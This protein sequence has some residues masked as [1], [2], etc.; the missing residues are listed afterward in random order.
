MAW[1]VCGRAGFELRSVP[2]KRVSDDSEGPWVARSIAN[3]SGELLFILLTHP[4]ESLGGRPASGPRGV[5]AG[6]GEGSRDE[7]APITFS[8]VCLRLPARTPLTPSFPALSKTGEA[9]SLPCFP[10]RSSAIN[11]VKILRVLRVLRPLRA[12]NR[13]KGL[14]VRGQPE[15]GRGPVSISQLW[16]AGAK[17]GGGVGCREEAA[18]GRV[19]ALLQP[20]LTCRF[21][22]PTSRSMTGSRSE[23]ELLSKTLAKG[24]PVATRSLYSHPTKWG[25]SGA[26]VPVVNQSPMGPLCSPGFHPM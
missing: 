8:Q 6:G 22:S 14:K 12:I 17:L 1:L 18:V 21:S 2:S 16:M 9:H 24:D 11:V 13:A 15:Q 4:Q 25:G 23:S 10:P 3:D 26:F 5:G 20:G 19:A 7:K